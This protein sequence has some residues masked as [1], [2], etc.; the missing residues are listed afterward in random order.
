[1][2]FLPSLSVADYVSTRWLLKLDIPAD[3]AR[4][5]SELLVND[6]AKSLKE[7]INLNT[8]RKTDKT[9]HFNPRF[10]YCVQKL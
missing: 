2:N 4:G 8:T 10:N 9:K 5:L 6:H 3:T 7:I 1:M